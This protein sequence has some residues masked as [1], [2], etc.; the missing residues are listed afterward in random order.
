MD[1]KEKTTSLILLNITEPTVTDFN[2]LLSPGWSGFFTTALVL[3]I[4]FSSLIQRSIFKLLKRRPDRG[5]NQI[6]MSQQVLNKAFLV[7]GKNVWWW[8]HIRS[9]CSCFYHFTPLPFWTCLCIH[10]RDWLGRW[11]AIF[12]ILFST[13]CHCS[14]VHIL[15]HIF[16]S[17]PLC[18]ATTNHGETWIISQS[19]IYW[20]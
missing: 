6:I 5:I 16:L 7:K 2:P 13:T 17:L 3:Y 1:F 14:S 10:W 12:L 20:A 19:S 15:L 9:A 11:V 8:C 18:C 4:L